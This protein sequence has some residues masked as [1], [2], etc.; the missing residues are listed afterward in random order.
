MSLSKRLLRATPVRLALAGAASLYMRLVLLTAR[1][2]RVMPAATQR[3]VD[4]RL[5]LICCF[6]HGRLMM[7]PLALP[8]RTTIHVL[9]SAHRDGLL[10][11]RA[12]RGLGIHTVASRRRP[13]GQSALRSM[14]RLLSEGR[15]VGITPD[16]PRG[17]RMRAKAGAIKAAQLSGAPLV[18]ASGAAS[19]RRLLHTWDRFCVALPFARYTI[20]IGEPIHVP[21]EASEAELE[22]LRLH[23]EAQLNALTAEADR[24]FGQPT[25]EPAAVHERAID[26]AKHAR[27]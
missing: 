18:P 21:R 2:E 12:V 15:W 5:P 26:R 13:G 11:A 14:L 10:I 3:L 7:M 27:A 4:E 6:W 19:R 9:I 20:L 1:W 23:L 24:R 8:R 22:R 25:V 16:G 17:P